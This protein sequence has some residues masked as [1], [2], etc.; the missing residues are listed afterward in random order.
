MNNILFIYIQKIYLEVI[1][2]IIQF[3]KHKY[4][5]SI[6]EYKLLMELHNKNIFTVKDLINY[7]SNLFQ[8]FN[9]NIN[10]YNK[11]NNKNNQNN[12][13]NNIKS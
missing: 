2:S 13:E 7:F 9:I 4:Y 5:I 3:R 8:Q 11:T 1:N 12:I 10:N 6:K